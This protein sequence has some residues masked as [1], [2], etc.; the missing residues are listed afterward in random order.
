MPPPAPSRRGAPHIPQVPSPP[1]T[2]R[3]AGWFGSSPRSA[4]SSRPTAP[5]TGVGTASGKGISAGLSAANQLRAAVVE[6]TGRRSLPSRRTPVSRGAGLVLSPGPTAPRRRIRA[7]AGEGERIWFLNA[8]MT[9][10]ATA[11]STGGDLCL[12][13]VRAPSGYATPL[14]VHHDEHEGFYVLEGALDVVCGEER[15]RAEAGSFA[16]LPVGIAHAFRVASE[17]PVR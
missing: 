10:K 12:I 3:R 4:A 7:S 11:G 8:D 6:L 17:E 15:Y 1:R 2:R 9:V 13:E 5:Q 14:H 16:F